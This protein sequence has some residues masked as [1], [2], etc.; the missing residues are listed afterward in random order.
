MLKKIA[1]ELLKKTSEKSINNATA[2]SCTCGV[3]KMPE[4]MKKSR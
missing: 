4:S 1:A 2:S 3:E